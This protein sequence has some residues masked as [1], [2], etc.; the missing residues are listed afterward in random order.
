MEKGTSRKPTTA[1]VARDVQAVA[2]QPNRQCKHACA[3]RI[4]EK[5]TTVFQQ[6]TKQSGTVFKL[7]VSS[8][9]LICLDSLS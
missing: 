1:R 5:F 8:I 9:S 6:L 4:C 3:N 7:K 2:G